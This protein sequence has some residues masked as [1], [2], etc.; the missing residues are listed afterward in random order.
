MKSKTGLL[1]IFAA[2]AAALCL[3]AC[4]KTSDSGK[5]DSGKIAIGTTTP[6]QESTGNPASDYVPTEVP[7]DYPTEVP[8]DYPTEAPVDTP[9][10]VPTDTPTPEP[11]KRPIVNGDPVTLSFVGDVF[12]S[13]GL[14]ANYAKKG[15]LGVVSQK[16]LDT[17]TGADFMIANHEYCCTD[18]DKS[19]ALTYQTYIEHQTT[20]KEHI[21][22]ELGID[23]AGYANNHGYD[24]GEQGFIDTLNILKSY[25][26][27]Y[28]G[29]GMNSE[30]SSDP[31]ILEK[32]G[33]RIAI[34]ASNGVITHKD[35]ISAP[36][37]PGQNA[38][39]DLKQYDSYGKTIEKIKK[40]KEECDLVIA[41]PHWG[42]ELAN[43]F[44]ALQRQYAYAYI[45]AGCDII[46]GSH[47]HVLQGM[48]YYKDSVIFYS[49]GNFL[50]GS[51][52][53]DTCVVTI[54]LNGDN[55]YS[56]KVLPCLSYSNRT[57]DVQTSTVFDLMTKYSA[58][59]KIEADGTVVKTK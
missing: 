16:V 44:N 58:N 52:K 22:A 18:I 27:L 8:A 55:S 45:D 56:M 7:A 35:W 24:Y 54:T 29:A 38:L 41:M 3:M 33:K 23:V 36:D 51:Y 11:T 14:A 49:L 46:I 30:E 19:N 15:I 20:D 48:E 10:E 12:I 39:Y 1:K 25:N 4:G 37:K 21:F 40:A 31:V 17:M 47:P 13:D 50:F 42:V 2:S 26:I 9:T 34:F 43:Q 32:N 57:D 5:T 28:V 53:R 6:G 59:A